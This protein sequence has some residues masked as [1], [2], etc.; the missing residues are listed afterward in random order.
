MECPYCDGELEQIDSYFLGRDT[1]N[2]LGDIFKCYNSEGF[3]TKEELENYR[4]KLLE[5]GY[6]REEVLDIEVCES[7]VDSGHFHT[8]V[9]SDGLFT[10]YP[11]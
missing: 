6:N 4:Q 9:N 8:S 7:E 3:E 2:I 5:E 1:N 11:C 10:G